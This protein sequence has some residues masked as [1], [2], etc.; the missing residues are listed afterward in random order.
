[1]KK[2]VQRPVQGQISK[3]RLKAEIAAPYKNNWLG[4]SVAAV[5]VIIWFVKNNPQLCKY[6]EGGV[7]YVVLFC[8]CLLS[9]VVVVIVVGI[10]VKM[11]GMPAASKVKSSKQTK[12]ALVRD[13]L[14]FPL[15]T[16]LLSSSFGR[17]A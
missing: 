10:A 12:W 6:E 16:P 4:L 2:L 14:L 9:V 11:T 13:T 8:C 1:M 17:V 7:E 15:A 5:A 3:D